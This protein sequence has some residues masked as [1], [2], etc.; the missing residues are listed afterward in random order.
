MASQLQRDEWHMFIAQSSESEPHQHLGDS[1]DCGLIEGMN[2][3][4]TSLRGVGNI[5]FKSLDYRTYM[6]IRKW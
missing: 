1:Q 5:R 3:M 2:V 6:E 4:L